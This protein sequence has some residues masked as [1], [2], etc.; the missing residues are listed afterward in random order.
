VGTFHYID[1]YRIALEYAGC[2]ILDM[3]PRVLGGKRI[4]RILGEDGEPDH[5]VLDDSIPT[6][7]QDVYA[8]GDVEKKKSL[9]KVFN[10]KI[11]KYDIVV[12]TG[13]SFT[14]KRQ[15][16]SEFYTNAIQ[17]AR[18]PQL[19]AV[20]TYL[21]LKSNDWAGADE[22]VDLVK[23]L[24]ILQGIIPP[25]DGEGD[26]PP[27]IPP[28][29]KQ[30]LDQAKQMAG[31]MKGQLDAATQALA[32]RDKTLQSLEGQVKAKNVE[33]LAKMY[34]ADKKAMSEIEKARAEVTVAHANAVV[35]AAENPDKGEIAGVVQALGALMT[36]M[37]GKIDALAASSTQIAEQLNTFEIS[38]RMPS[39]PP[40]RSARSATGSHRMRFEVN[41][42]D[43]NNLDTLHKAREAYN[44]AHPDAPAADMP[45]F[46]QRLMDQ[47]VAGALEP[48]VPRHAIRGHDQD[49]RARGRNAELAKDVKT[50]STQSAAPSASA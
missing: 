29:V 37:Q 41:V 7:S 15:E 47:A 48:I 18:D 38:A 11:G 22:A 45:S 3:M 26:E 6:A 33:A 19:A 17:A 35:A 14:T 23:K 36:E 32:E 24:P 30:A 5:V 16:A 20:L 50:A 13:P 2:I 12:T 34:E 40:V 8:E 44:V 25:T 9:G 21:S 4:A 49:R 27:E 46:V 39:A 42:D 31:H 28:E 10:L 43:G 1:N